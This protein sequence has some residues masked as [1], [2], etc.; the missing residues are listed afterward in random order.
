M[1]KK[2]KKSTSAVYPDS[3]FRGT[4]AANVGNIV[5]TSGRCSQML[6]KMG[7]IWTHIK[8]SKM[9]TSFF[10]IMNVEDAGLYS[11]ARTTAFELFL[12]NNHDDDD[13]DAMNC[14]VRLCWYS[15]SIPIPALLVIFIVYNIPLSPPSLEVNEN[16]IYFLQNFL[17]YSSTGFGVGYT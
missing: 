2:M 17:A 5:V 6:T 4:S 16:G 13:D 8:R 9:V 15:L 10:D 14:M 11:R 3:H 12:K 7:Q 1:K